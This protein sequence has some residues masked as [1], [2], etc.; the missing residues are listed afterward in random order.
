[1]TKRNNEKNAL[2]EACRITSEAA[3][4]FG[5]KPEKWPERGELLGALDM[6]AGILNEMNKL[7]MLSSE[8]AAPLVVNLANAYDQ[9]T[10]NAA[11]FSLFAHLDDGLLKKASGDCLVREITEEEKVVLI[12]RIFYMSFLV[13]SMFLFNREERATLWRTR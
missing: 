8:D 10:V 4:N 7:D 12:H 6:I 11:F 9:K 1:M 13:N 3:K 5:E 2:E